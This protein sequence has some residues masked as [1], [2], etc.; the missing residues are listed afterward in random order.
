MTAIVCGDH[1]RPGAAERLGAIV[2][3][4]WCVKPEVPEIVEGDTLVVAA[5]RGEFSLGPVQRALRRGGFDPLGVP[6]LDMGPEDYSDET[7][8]RVRLE[9]L[10]A[11]AAAFAGSRPEQIRMVVPERVSRRALLTL[12]V[13]EYRAGPAV[14]LET[15]RADG[16][17]AACVAACP[18]GAITWHGGAIDVDRV[19]CVSCGRCVAVCPTGAMVN[20][21]YTSAQLYAEVTTLAAAVGGAAG[22][23]FVCSRGPL[24][25]VPGGWYPLVVPCVGMLPPHWIV[26]PLL[27]GLSTVA[28][29]A[30]SCGVEDDA[31]Q[32][33][34]AVVEYAREWIEGSAVTGRIV[35][36][37]GPVPESAAPLSAL[38]DPFGPLERSRSPS[39]SA[40][41]VR[42]GTKSPPLGL[43]T[44]D[45]TTCTGC[46][47]C[48]V[49]CPTGALL[50]R[51]SNA[52]VEIG[53]SAAACTAC[54]TC[55]TRCPEIARGAITLDRRVDPAAIE[56]GFQI[57]VRSEVRTCNRC[58][59]EIAT[60]AALR[61]IAEAL[62]DHAAL[63]SITG[64]CLDCRGT[65]MVF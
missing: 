42:S 13:P 1:L 6:M 57:Q 19:A 29:A 5:C 34:E 27:M 62:G 25:A 65:R 3:E 38:S 15:C 39:L 17:C 10:M 2:L 28:V 9:A 26:A 48:A 46:E 60:A 31:A 21:A 44:L 40:W 23:V 64:L 37:F 51:R 4:G 8:L 55:L 56:A 32:R 59:K 43:V 50:V 11:H 36:C 30:C 47:A 20:P 14:D 54:G 35:P 53:F 58:G 33:V 61:R 7:R 49:G 52:L 16:G 12:A 18:H 24:A 41:Q 22:V 45:Q 63:P